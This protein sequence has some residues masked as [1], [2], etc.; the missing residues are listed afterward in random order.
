ML[1][2]MTPGMREVVVGY[3]GSERAR[4]ALAA[5]RDLAERGATVTVVSAFWIPQEV[6]H[7]EFFEDL[8]GG[9]RREAEEKLES[10]HAVFEG[11]GL[12][13]RYQAVDGRAEDVLAD[14]ARERNADLIV[15]GSRGLGRMRAMI[16]SSVLG[17][18]HEAP[19]PVLVVPLR[20]SVRAEP[21]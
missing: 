6:K 9:F 18:L 5:A 1:S 13:V 20:D 14:L 4:A 11:A 17:L 19:C 21:G 2:H 8:V 3:D 16:G 15:V 12:D 10:A 7:Y